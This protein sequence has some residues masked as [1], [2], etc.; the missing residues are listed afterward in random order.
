MRRLVSQLLDLAGDDLYLGKGLLGPGAALWGACLILDAAG[1]DLY[2]ADYA[3]QGAGL[4][5][6]AWLEDRGGHDLYT[7]GALAQGA[8]CVGLGILRDIN[9]D[10]IYQVGLEG[11]A[12]AGLRALGLLIDDHGTDRYIAGGRERDH[13]RHPEHYLSM[14]QG[15]AIGMRPHAGG[16]LAALVDRE[17]ND[18][19]QADVYGQGVSYWYAIGMLLDLDGHD[20]YNLR[21]YGQGSGI[22]LSSGLLWDRAGHDH[23]TG[24]SLSQ[25]CAHDYALGLLVDHAGHDVYTADHFSQGR[26]MNN[27]VGV[28]VDA[29]GNDAYFGIRLDTVQGIGDPGGEREYGSLS[30]LLD[31]D[32]RDSYSCAATNGAPT[33]RPFYGVVYDLAPPATERAT[34][35]PATNRWRDAGYE[36]LISAISRY[37]NTEARRTKKA[38]ARR[39]LQARGTDALHWLINHCH[40]ENLWIVLTAR[41]LVRRLDKDE[42]VPILIQALDAEHPDIVRMAAYLLGY[43]TCPEHAARLMPLLENH[44]TAGPALR[45]LGKW[46]VT[47]A[48]PAMVAALDHEKE[49]RRILAVNALK[50]VGDPMVASNLVKMLDEPVFTVRHTAAEALKKLGAAT[51]DTLRQA[52]PGATP[53]ARPLIVDVLETFKQ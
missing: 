36:T 10:D 52:L 39:E 43:F 34:D 21:E 44:K 29:T 46:Q 1:D 32:G 31:L 16:G 2:R 7:A 15:F 27:S 12:F 6:C 45:T 49:R 11:Q 13:E 8:A 33:L 23:Y 17:G 25:G 42:A 14:A 4:Y 26:G 47:N 22:H 51:G 18:V 20:T 24:W 5:G 40:L 50:D 28:L 19:Y 48:I 35:E 53:R 3:G 41:E 37:G 38:L 30:L 9:G